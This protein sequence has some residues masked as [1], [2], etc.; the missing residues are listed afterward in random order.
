MKLATCNE[1]TGEVSSWMDAYIAEVKDADKEL[2]LENK[3]AK[4]KEGKMNSKN[5]S[6]RTSL[7]ILQQQLQI[8][9]DDMVST[10]QEKQ[11]DDTI[12][13]NPKG[14]GIL[15]SPNEVT[16]ST[17]SNSISI[18]LTSEQFEQLGNLMKL[19]IDKHFSEI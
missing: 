13:S 17:I 3:A 7:V 19:H 6:T 4:E 14:K 15:L 11:V 1:K 10:F 18:P 8:H 9:D 12:G 2:N 5:T 16:P